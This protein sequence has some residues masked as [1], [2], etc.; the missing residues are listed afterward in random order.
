FDGRTAA[1][2]KQAGFK[3]LVFVG[4]TAHS[5]QRKDRLVN[6][7]IHYGAGVQ[8]F[9][10]TFDRISNPKQPPKPEEE[11][12]AVVKGF[13]AYKNASGGVWLESTRELVT[14]SVLAD[15]YVGAQFGGRGGRFDGVLFLRRS[16]NGL[17]EEFLADAKM[18][19]PS[20]GWYLEN[21]AGH[22]VGKDVTFAGMDAAWYGSKRP[23]EERQRLGD[24][25]FIDVPDPM[26]EKK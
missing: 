26:P 4:N 15:H 21:G 7:L 18:K 2:I 1:G 16:A 22:V 13:T 11:G 24:W 25:R 14:D 19:A 6:S 10:L 5:N 9:G 3:K 23:L 20:T 8:N 12:V 17:G